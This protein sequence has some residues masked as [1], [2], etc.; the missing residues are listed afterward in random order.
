M[1][2]ESESSQSHS[3]E[4]SEAFRSAFH[5]FMGS[6]VELGYQIYERQEGS[7]G[8]NAG[9]LTFTIRNPLG[10]RSLVFRMDPESGE[11]HATLK[12]QVIPGEENWDLDSLFR[13]NGYSE[14]D[15]KAVQ[16]MAGEWLYDS[17]ARHYFGTIFSH[18]PKLLEPNFKLQ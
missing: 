14:L 15:S 17:I 13:R 9:W 4:F 8:E 3:M 1:K 11:F 10:G 6:E 7:F 18:C 12:V 2:E 5:E 16:K